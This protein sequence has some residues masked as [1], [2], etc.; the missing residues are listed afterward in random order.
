MMLMSAR[1]FEVLISPQFDVVITISDERM[2]EIVGI[3]K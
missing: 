3:K 1:N 2:Q